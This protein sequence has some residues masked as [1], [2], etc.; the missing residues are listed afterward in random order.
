MSPIKLFEAKKVRSHY[1]AEKEI[2]Y[3][4]VIDV[5]QILTDST[6]PKRYWT[7]LKKKLN[8]E[9]SEAYDKIVQL[10]ILA[11]DGK[12]GENFLPPSQKELE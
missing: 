3:F 10:K 11:E 6:I 8:N 4:S 12:T 5:I 1:D 9:G 2:W 7:D